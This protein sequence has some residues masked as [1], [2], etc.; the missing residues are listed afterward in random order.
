MDGSFHIQKLVG[1]Y[2]ARMS[3]NFIL[4]WISCLYESIMICTNKFGTGWVVLP[5]KPHTFGN[6]WHTICCAMSV[7]V[8]F[9]GIV[10]GKD[11]PTERGKREFEADYGETGGLMMRM[12][13]PLFVKGK[14]VV[15]DSEFCVL[16]GIVGMLSHGVYG[17]T[18]IKKK[19]G[20]STAR[21]IPLRHFSKTRG[22]GMFMLFEVICMG[23][24]TRYSVLR[25]LIIS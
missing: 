15:V 2:N 1:A 9:V 12:A 3:T 5:R 25:R 18:V 16:K 22:L 10:E 17:M 19:N 14:D 11:Q 4:G 20:P 24:S 8:F 7:V 6:K 23:I 21:D 13:N